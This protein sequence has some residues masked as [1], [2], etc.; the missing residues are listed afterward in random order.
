MMKK[1][2]ALFLCLSLLIGQSA[3]AAEPFAPHWTE[4]EG[5]MENGGSM[6]LE[7]S[8]QLTEWVPFETENTAAI[9]ALLKHCGFEVDYT[10]QTGDEQ[11]ALT[12]TV[13][14]QP[15]ATVGQKTTPEGIEWYSDLNDAV[16]TL[17]AGSQTQPLTLMSDNERADG[18]LLWEEVLLGDIPLEE[19]AQHMIQLLMAE[20]KAAK[21]TKN[22]SKIGRAAK[23]YKI[24][25]DG[26]G[27]QDI[28]TQAAEAMNSPYAEAFASQLTF[29]GAKNIFTLYENKEGTIL[30]L[31]FSGRAAFAGGDARKVTLTWGFKADDETRLDTL[32]LTAPSVKGK[33]KLTVKFTWNRDW[34]AAANTQ[35]LEGSI[36]STLNSVKTS[37][38][39][40]VD[41]KNAKALNGHQITGAIQVDTTENDVKETLILKPTIQTTKQDQRPSFRGSI[42]IETLKSKKPMLT[43]AVSVAMD[44]KVDPIFAPVELMEVI[45]LEDLSEDALKE[46]DEELAVLLTQ[47]LLLAMMTLPQ[48]DLAALQTGISQANWEK[49]VETAQELAY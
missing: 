32:S 6:H 25:T 22:V 36:S 47:R 5:V 27:A 3:L 43:A 41:L 4:L 39:V 9:N 21:S 13:D 24:T 15:V 20:G 10:G 30:G 34:K 48:E 44:P 23:T 38:T 37:Q 1:L 19:L 31:N 40:S 46:T 29:S 26:P 45:P 49:V 18:L 2:A 14:G 8:G 33:N 17:E 12:I 35:R 11:Y 7:L 16:Y 28:V 42:Q